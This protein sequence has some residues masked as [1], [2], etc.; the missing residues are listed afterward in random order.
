MPRT[1][2]P[3]AT[4]KRAPSRAKPAPAATAGPTLHSAA[5]GQTQA[6][7]R[8]L[9]ALPDTVDFRDA[10]YVPALIAVPAVSDIDA[11]RRSRV[12]VLDQGSE[13]ACTG[14]ALAAVAHHL[15]RSRGLLKP[16]DQVSP[17]MLYTMARR[18]DE[19]S[20][21]NYEGSSARGAMKGWH[22]HG[23]CSLGLWPDRDGDTSLG[24][25]RAADAT[26]RPL[27]AYFRVNHRDLVAMHAAIAEVGILYATC[28][29]HEGWQE[30]RP[31]QR[32]IA[33]RE[34]SIGGHAVAIVGYDREGFWIQNSWGPG[35]GDRGLARV[36]YADWLANGTDVWVA[37]L[38]APV[39]IARSVMVARVGG[40]SR[41]QGGLIDPALRPHI[42]TAKN[43]GVLDAKGSFGLT[44][45]D[46]RGIMQEDFPRLTKGWA[47][48]RMV[49]YAHGGLVPEEDAVAQLAARREA[50]MQAGAHPLAIIWRSSWWN[51]IC[52]IMRDALAGRR[53]EGVLDAA[54]DFMIER[55]D[56]TLETLARQLG[57]RAIWNEM[58][59]NARLLTEGVQ[60]AARLVA[61]HV[62]ELVRARRLDELHLAGH[63]AGAI[64]LAPLARHLADAGV[65]IRSLSLW[66]PACTMAVFDAEYRPLIEGGQIGAFDLYTLDD[67]TERD[68]DCA[69][70]YRKSLLY[71]V[72]HALEA[73]AR[74]PL[75]N[76]D[77]EPLL[78]LARDV[79]RHVK[80]GFWKPGTRN[81]HVAPAAAESR[82][83][84]HSDFDN[85]AATLRTTLQR[86]T[87][88]M[89]SL[90]GPAPASRASQRH[91]RQE[92]AAAL[93]RR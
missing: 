93:A 74:D 52:N 15:L 39:S 43:D 61:G 47:T 89:Q 49:I 54:L 70:I 38:G 27:G 20:G 7:P 65:P 87:G 85:D 28:S 10:V 72:S 31:G 48:R 23:L 21:E 25:A 33:F 90:A 63:S 2:K 82:A 64:V 84:R 4:A 77:G 44:E 6:R 24:E 79:A 92:L 30:V 46:L 86:I 80:A 35:W 51:T 42:V 41:S 69:K 1:P 17:W 59:E 57:G 91:K 71:L 75:S 19:W 40:S 32:D 36:A 76:P 53:A 12:P 67:A 9:A 83:A 13:G 66:A 50:M 26:E 18:Y 88:Q 11:Y 45:A 34:G 16:A 8:L 55:T 14:Y 5:R 81:W 58:K 29:V 3:A 22:K 78:G 68:D 56:D 73:R 37:A 60:G 62:V